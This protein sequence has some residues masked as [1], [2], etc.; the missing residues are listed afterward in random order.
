MFTSALAAESLS[1]DIEEGIGGTFIIDIL[2]LSDE[3]LLRSESD[4]DVLLIMCSDVSLFVVALIMLRRARL[5]CTGGVVDRTLWLIS[6]G[7]GSSSSINLEDR[8]DTVV[9]TGRGGVMGSADARVDILLFGDRPRAESPLRGCL[10]EGDGD[11]EV[12]IHGVRA[13]VRK[14]SATERLGVLG[15]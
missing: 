1:E 7:G 12:E 13:R 15:L 5:L 3:A 14:V 9:T 8:G 6:G 4:D 11:L 10:P 2:K